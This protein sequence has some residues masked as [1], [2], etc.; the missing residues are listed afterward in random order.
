MQGFLWQS[1]SD[2]PFSGTGGVEMG[3][4][5]WCSVLRLSSNGTAY[6][7]RECFL[8]TGGTKERLSNRWARRAG[9]CGE[10]STSASQ[11]SCNSK[12]LLPSF[13]NTLLQIPTFRFPRRLEN[14]PSPPN[15][16]SQQNYRESTEWHP[17][18]GH[19]SPRASPNPGHSYSP[20]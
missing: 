11:G 2:T 15:T 12:T 6:A 3:Q 9:G 10:R 18:G 4:M 8:I 20:Y 13:K 1:L 7:G 5:G 19:S 14:T 16:L 17:S